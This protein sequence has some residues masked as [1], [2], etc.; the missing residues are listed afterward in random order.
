MRQTEAE[1]ETDRERDRERE[2]ERQSE[3]E[4]EI[5]TRWKRVSMRGVGERSGRWLRGYGLNLTLQT[6]VLI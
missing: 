6:R 3:S 5:T 4:S 2:I 1:T